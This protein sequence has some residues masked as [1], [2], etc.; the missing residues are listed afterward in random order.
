M[1]LILVVATELWSGFGE[2]IGGP[3]VRKIQKLWF[4]SLFAVKRHFKVSLETPSFYRIYLIIIDHD[5]SL[6]LLSFYIMFQ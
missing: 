3:S 1:R 4:L 5:C 2:P 6:S